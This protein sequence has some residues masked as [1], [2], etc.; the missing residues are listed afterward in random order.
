MTATVPAGFG[1][2]REAVVEKDEGEDGRAVKVGSGVAS[3]S[4][5]GNSRS[6]L[7]LSLI[8]A[9]EPLA[10]RVR[11]KAADAHFWDAFHLCLS[12][13]V[14]PDSA[15]TLPPHPP[16]RTSSLAYFS[17]GQQHGLTK[18]EYFETLRQQLSTSA[19]MLD[20]Y[21]IAV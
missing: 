2:T 9:G 10:A 20:L 11:L 1:R 16:S 19:L 6:M 13:L 4:G 8:A 12:H 5:I 17:S 7:A 3:G 14:F 15:S 21:S 18:S